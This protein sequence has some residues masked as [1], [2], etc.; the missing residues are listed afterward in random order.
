VIRFT[1]AHGDALELFEFTKEVFD[2]MPP[3]VHLCIERDG[4]GA[5]WM[6]GYDDLGAAVVEV[7]DNIVVVESLV[8]EQRAE[9]DTFDEWS[10]ADAVEAVA[11]HQA[12]THEITQSIRQRQYL[13]C[14]PALRATYGLA[15]SPPFAPCP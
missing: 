7:S 4:Y 1:G 15:R 8:S 10:H 3:F 6:L 5:S 9:L 2:Q 13:G 14:H 11:G 12:E